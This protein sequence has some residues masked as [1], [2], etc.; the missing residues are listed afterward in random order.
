MDNLFDEIIERKGT[1]SLKYDFIA[2]NGKP[3]DILPLWVADMDFRVPKQVIEEIQKLAQHGIFGYSDCKEGYF[4]A[5]QGWYS[6]YFNWETEREWIVKT[7]GVVFAINTAIRALTKKGDAVLIQRPVY[8]PFSQSILNN[9][10]VLVNNPLVYQDGKYSVNFEEFEKLIVENQVKMFILCSPH[11]PVGRVWTKEELCK[12]GDICV[13]NNVIVVSDEIHSDFVYEG[14]EH[15]VFAKLKPEY[16]ERS[17]TCTSPSK[18]FNLAGLQISNIFI[19]NAQIRN[20]FQKEIAKTGY[21]E[22]NTMGIVAC[23]SAY[24]NGRPWLDALK[25]YLAGN[26]AYIH[27]FLAERLPKVKLVEPQGTYLVW[28]DCRALGLTPEQLEDLVVNRAKLWTDGGAMFGP[29]GEGFQRI[30]IAC[31]RSTIKQALLQLEQAVGTLACQ[32]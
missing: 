23:Q 13:K 9:E 32:P 1:N 4:Q 26:V 6:R 27:Q 16:A 28:L 12:M 2:E 24:E 22:L 14:N 3:Q 10:R 30:N 8:Y 17:I 15:Q 7:P 29:E 11:N 18:S 31:P 20:L 25:T 19:P 5:I 21:C